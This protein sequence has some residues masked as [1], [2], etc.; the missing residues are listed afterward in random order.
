V[1]P[2]V[3]TA[4]GRQAVPPAGRARLAVRTWPAAAPPD[5]QDPDPGRAAR[6][7]LFL[8]H[9]RTDSAEVFDPVVRALGGRWSA[10][11]ADA[12]GHGGSAWRPSWRYRIAPQ[13][14][15]LRSVLDRLPGLLPPFTGIVV[16]GHSMGALT[17]TRLAAA[18]PGQVRHLVLEEPATGG[19]WPSRALRARD[20]AAERRLLFWARRLRRLPDAE[21]AAGAR[22]HN[23]GWSDEEIRLWGE[24][25]RQ[26]SLAAVAAPMAWGTPLIDLLDGVGCPVTLVRGSVGA[27]VVDA[28]TARRLAARCRGGCEIVTLATGHNVRRDDAAGFVTVLREVLGRYG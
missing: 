1:Q 20:F 7:A 21:L 26:M 2:F 12:P 18:R 27:D 6:P 13:A 25:K 28:A 19:P 24:A 14:E 16:H 4:R 17:A 8:C 3:A 22:E 10:V 15:P 5:R 11:A 23:P 9:G